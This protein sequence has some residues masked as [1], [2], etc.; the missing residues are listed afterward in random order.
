MEAYDVFAAAAE[1]NA[2]KVVL[3]GERAVRETPGGAHGLDRLSEPE[4]AGRGIAPG[5][6]PLVR[7]VLRLDLL[8]ADP[9]HAWLAAIAASPKP[10]EMSVIFPS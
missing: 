9:G 2:L 1:T 4:R 8:A 7:R 5:P 3:E 6:T 10:T